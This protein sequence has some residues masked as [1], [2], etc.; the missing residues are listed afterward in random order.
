MPWYKKVKKSDINNAISA[1]FAAAGNWYLSHENLRTH[2]IVTSGICLFYSFSSLLQLY[3]IEKAYAK[4]EAGLGSTCNI[5]DR[6][7]MTTVAAGLYM[8]TWGVLVGI[9]WATGVYNSGTASDTGD[10]ETSG[11]QS[12][13][14]LLAIIFTWMVNTAFTYK[15]F[16]RCA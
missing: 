15:Y 11:E 16:S 13:V 14:A 10:T 6:R 7:L 2:A 4:V 3:E 9:F 12:I 1:G 8:S 5:S